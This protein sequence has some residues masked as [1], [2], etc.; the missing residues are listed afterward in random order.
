MYNSD[1][2]K[3]TEGLLMT[4]LRPIQSQWACSFLFSYVRYASR[5]TCLIHIPVLEIFYLYGYVMTDIYLSSYKVRFQQKVFPEKV[6]IY[7]TWYSGAVKRIQFMQPND[8]WYT[9]WETTTVQYLKMLRTFSPDFDVR[10]EI[11]A[12]R[13]ILNVS[14]LLHKFF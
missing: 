3:N 5:P 11:D 14:S 9:V 10:N 13:L 4:L 6:E 8:K 7:E 2:K 1:V 12:I